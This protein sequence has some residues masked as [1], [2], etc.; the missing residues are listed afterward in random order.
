MPTREELQARLV[1]ELYNDPEGRKFIEDWAKKKYPT[2]SIPMAEL[3]A[4]REQILAE[5]AK[6]KQELSDVLGQ[7]K[8]RRAWQASV[9]VAKGKWDLRDDDIP[10]VEK[11]MTDEGVASHDAA[12]ELFRARARVAP[13]RSGL[14]APM[15][16]PGVN[17]A[18]G[19]DYKGLMENPD[20]W[21][22]QKAEQVLHEID[23]GR[24]GR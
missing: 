2:A 19:D 16:I 4:E 17:G 23:R 13:S 6:H 12:A 11:I 24:G 8:S 21:A 15:L 20:Q 9:D 10:A 3:R 14:G 5:V 1:E 7:E 18:G 22:R